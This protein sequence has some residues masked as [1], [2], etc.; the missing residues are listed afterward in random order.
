MFF[1]LLLQVICGHIEEHYAKDGALRDATIDGKGI[2]PGIGD[3]DSYGPVG[4]ESGKEGNGLCAG[5]L[6]GK[7]LQAVLEAKP[8]EGLGIVDGGNKGGGPGIFQVPANGVLQVHQEM[9]DAAALYTA[10][11][12]VLAGHLGGEPV[13]HIGFIDL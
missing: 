5:S 9:T 2:R 7:G 6:A 11:L 13:E 3:A 4:E 12:V 10:V 1:C 8:V